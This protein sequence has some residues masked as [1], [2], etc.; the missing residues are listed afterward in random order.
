MTAISAAPKTQNF[1]FQFFNNVHRHREINKE[2]RDFS[3]ELKT[4]HPNLSH[5]SG[6]MF[7][8]LITHA[9]VVVVVVFRF[10]HK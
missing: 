10:F 3:Q 8:G 2:N 4:G 9:G 6:K 7:N 5:E 1:M